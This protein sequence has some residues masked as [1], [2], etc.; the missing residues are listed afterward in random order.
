MVRMADTTYRIV[1]SEDDGFA[2][3]IAR[4]GMLPQ[5]AAGFA[6]EAEASDWIARTSDFGK[7]L[8]PSGPPPA[9]GGARLDRSGRDRR[10]A[11]C[12]ARWD[13]RGGLAKRRKGAGVALEPA[14]PGMTRAAAAGH[15]GSR[16]SDD[17]T[18]SQ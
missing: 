18:G 4:S 17:P 7:R 11:G 14:A 13:S 16:W 2:V 8:I 5:T 3:E 1:G 12:G 6:T 9:G 15:G 10:A